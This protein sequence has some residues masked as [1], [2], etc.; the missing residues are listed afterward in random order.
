MA[1]FQ[2]SEAYQHRTDKPLQ[3][4]QLWSGLAENLNKN[5]RFCTLAMQRFRRGNFLGSGK[6]M[7]LA[8]TFSDLS[9]SFD[10]TLVRGPA[11]DLVIGLSG[12]Q[13]KKST[14]PC[15]L[16]L[17][18]WL[19]RNYFCSAHPK[20]ISIR[21]PTRISLRNLCVSA[22]LRLHF[23]ELYRIK[24]SL[25]SARAK[26][27]SRTWRVSGLSGRSVLLEWFR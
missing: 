13:A 27:A 1:C 22:S 15:P 20:P 19:V 9:E 10:G 8:D 17:V 3:N 7:G 16:N 4:G 25:S 21:M 23:P 5:L 11:E 26:P 2:G 6:G 24:R 12:R 18:D 14:Q